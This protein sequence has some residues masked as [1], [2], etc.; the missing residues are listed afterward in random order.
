[1]TEGKEMAAGGVG[2]QSPCPGQDGRGTGKG[3]RWTS[4]AGG[5]GDDR[6]R[7]SAASSAQ[8][9]DLMVFSSV[10]DPPFRPHLPAG[11]PGSAPR[12]P[13]ENVC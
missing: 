2:E 3:H 8:G 9:R 6:M 7:A 13:S 1:M 4:H 10:Q 12:G 5:G 11:S